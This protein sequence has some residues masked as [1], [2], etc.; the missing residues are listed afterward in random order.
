MSTEWN[1]LVSPEPPPWAT[2]FESDDLDEVRAFVARGSGEHS[3][4]THQ[5]GALGFSLARVMGPTV[6]VGWGR[7]ALDM[8]IRGSV[9]QPVLHVG[10]PAG[11]LYRFGRRSQ[12]ANR[13][14]VMF[15]APGLE[16]TR[17]SPG[18]SAGAIA[19]QHSRLAHEIEARCDRGGDL[20]FRAR[21]VEVN[22]AERSRLHSAVA[23]F[24]RATGG[25][26][27]VQIQRCEARL[28]SCVVDMLM[29]E[30]AVARARTMSTQRIADLETWIEAHLDEPITVGRLCAQAGIGERGLQKSFVS[31]RG[32]SPMRFVA[33]RRL[34][35][36]RRL[37]TAASG[38]VDVTSVAVRLGFGHVGRFAQLYRQAFGE[39]PSE[40]LRQSSRL[41]HA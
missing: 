10:V 40:S 1:P 3:R 6:A 33:E 36:A 39:V 26:D 28:L 20:V 7:A 5:S 9:R 30:S 38:R 22:Q 8:T 19:F 4:V 2:R 23:E 18:G 34:A 21:Q 35:A 32:M 15:L 29:R 31:R 13:S 27:P 25:A 41:P 37:L 16:F 17:R 14:S 11:S 24:A 12:S